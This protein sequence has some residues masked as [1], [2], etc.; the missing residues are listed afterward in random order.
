MVTTKSAGVLDLSVFEAIL[1]FVV[2]SAVLF[3]LK[4]IVSWFVTR[5]QRRISY[6]TDFCELEHARAENWILE[7]WST[8]SSLIGVAYMLRVW[9]SQHKKG[10]AYHKSWAIFCTSFFCGTIYHGT[11]MTPAVL[12]SFWVGSFF[13]NVLVVELRKCGFISAE[14]S[15][16]SSK[17]LWLFRLVPVLAYLGRGSESLSVAHAT[18]VLITGFTA[19]VTMATVWSIIVLKRVDYP[20]IK[21]HASCAMLLGVKDSLARAEP[22]LCSHSV[23]LGTAYHCFWHIVV[24]YSVAHMCLLIDELRKGHMYKNGE[25]DAPVIKRKNSN[26]KC[27]SSVCS[28]DQYGITKHMQS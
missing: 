10:V 8:L 4:D 21:R 24:C 23:G 19:I 1:V 3:P 18:L 14:S 17:S 6:Q 26:T 28:R 5:D 15:A 16:W 12:G 7:P 13:A 11:G 9:Y 22:V 2:G 25:A 27:W 20:E